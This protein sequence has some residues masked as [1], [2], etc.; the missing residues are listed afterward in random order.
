V[1]GEKAVQVP[2]FPP[3]ISHGLR[4]DR[5][6]GSALKTSCVIRLNFV[7]KFKSYLTVRTG[8]RCYGFQSVTAVQGTNRGL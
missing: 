4:Q 6:W 7:E 3:R 5:M 8:S 1:L 2:L